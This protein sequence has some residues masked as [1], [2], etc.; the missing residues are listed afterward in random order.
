M[1]RQPFLTHCFALVIC[2]HAKTGKWLCVK[3][4][5]NRGWWIAGGLVEPNEDFI[6]GAKR[7]TMEEAGVEIELK[8]V[9]R[10]EH[11]LMGKQSARMRVI[12]YAISCTDNPKQISDDESELA[13]WLS[14]RE[15]QDLNNT[16][17]G[18]RGNEIIDWPIYIEKGGLIA[19]I[20]FFVDEGVQINFNCKTGYISNSLTQLKEDKQVNTQ[21]LDLEKGLINSLEID[22]FKLAKEL[23]LRGANPNI[24]INNKKWTPLHYAIKVKSIDLVKSL[25]LSGAKAEN[26][27]HKK[28]SCLHFAVQSNL[29]FIK[30]LII[31]LSHYDENSLILL[32]NQ[33]DEFGDTPLHIVCRDIIKEK[34]NDSAS[35]FKL[36][37]SLGA[38]VNIK[39][40][41][42]ITPSSII[43]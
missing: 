7:E 32:L 42:G 9:L 41:E 24:I 21:I 29:E 22:D 26:Q 39:N 13:A 36:L 5:R 4:T 1:N 27:T 10:V 33:Q 15:I 35:I 40:N 2:Q 25:L 19:P 28:R 43:S 3:E 37:V 38:D 18:L 31:S 6:Q 16:K 11:S 8:G 17:P 14:V 30:A 20:D 23:L 34:S 12:F